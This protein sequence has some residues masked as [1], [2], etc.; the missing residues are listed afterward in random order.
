ML[1]SLKKK[2]IKKHVVFAFEATSHLLKATWPVVIAKIELELH[3]AR[4]KTALLRQHPCSPPPSLPP[5]SLISLF[6]FSSSSATTN[7]TGNSWKACSAR[8][9]NSTLLFKKGM[10]ERRE[11]DKRRGWRRK[12]GGEGRYFLFWTSC[13]LIRQFDFLGDGVKQLKRASLYYRACDI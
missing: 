9:N 1:L 3:L 7:D 6:F 13:S 12:W 5:F 8:H 4:H 10:V 11:G 2:G